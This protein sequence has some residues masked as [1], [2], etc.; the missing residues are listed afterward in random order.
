MLF[1]FSPAVA[2]AVLATI[3]ELDVVSAHVRFIE[4]FGDYSLVRGVKLGHWEGLAV[5]NHGAHQNPGQ[6]DV[7]AFSDPVVPPCCK[8]FW[9]KQKRHR[10]WMEQGCGATLKLIEDYYLKTNQIVNGK[11]IARPLKPARGYNHGSFVNYNFFQ[12]PVPIEGYVQTGAETLEYAKRRQIAQATPGGWIQITTWQV[13]ADGAGP[14]RCRLD[15]S[16]TGKEFGP[17]LATDMQPGPGAGKE[18]WKSV[19]A[20]G[21][22]KRHTLRVRIPGNVKCTAQYGNMKNICMLRCE[23]FAANGP[24]GGC[25]PFQA[26]YPEPEVQP[27]PEAKTVTVTV[28]QPEPTPQTGDSGIDIENTTPEDGYYKVKRNIDDSTSEKV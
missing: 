11:I 4:A 18:K 1:K 21:N 19:W 13:N 6:Y 12:G 15:E 27:A 8:S 20:H 22:N 23:N 24:F 26:I 5:K 7:V 10:V 17:W 9:H 2:F 16:G 14:F 25:V 28:G 3:S